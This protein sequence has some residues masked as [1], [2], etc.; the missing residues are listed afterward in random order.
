MSNI[1]TINQTQSILNELLRYSFSQIFD[2]APA[3]KK[4]KDLLQDNQDTVE[5]LISLVFCSIML[6]KPKEAKEL[7]DKTWSIGGNLS[8][9]FEL[10]KN[11]AY[12]F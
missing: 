12:I 11:S 10:V 5:I 2:I 4:L 3:E 7:S 9:F 6:G 1:E 8:H